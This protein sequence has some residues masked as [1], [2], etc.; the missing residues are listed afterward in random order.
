MNSVSPYKKRCQK[1]R[2]IKNNS[3]CLIVF[4]L[5]LFLLLL[6]NPQLSNSE[7]SESNSIGAKAKGGSTRTSY[8]GSYNKAAEKN[9]VLGRTKLK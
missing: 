4:F 5:G 1:P 6:F 8:V 2:E 9:L 3:L 7:N